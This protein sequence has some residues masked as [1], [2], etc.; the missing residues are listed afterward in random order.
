MIFDVPADGGFEPEYSNGNAE[1]APELYGA[2]SS[3]GI[4]IKIN[5]GPWPGHMSHIPDDPP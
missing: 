5:R 4:Q 1:T 2:P 3:E